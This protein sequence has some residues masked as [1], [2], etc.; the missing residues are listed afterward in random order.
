MVRRLQEC[1]RGFRKRYRVRNRLTLTTF[2]PPFLYTFF[3]IMQPL[4]YKIYSE[5]C[6]SYEQFGSKLYDDMFLG[7]QDNSISYLYNEDYYSHH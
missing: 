2:F 1:Q 4:T 7:Y 3:P 6:K 5:V